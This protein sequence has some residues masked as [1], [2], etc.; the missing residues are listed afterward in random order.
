MAT[1]VDLENRPKDS[2]WNN[3]KEGKTS[4][5][6]KGKTPLHPS[7]EAARRRRAIPLILP[8]TGKKIVF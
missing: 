5:D 1:K 3:G 2:G 8:S 4:A 6:G 7:W